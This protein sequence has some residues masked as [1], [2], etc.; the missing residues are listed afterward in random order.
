MEEGWVWGRGE[1][2]RVR[3]SEME[4]GETEVRMKSMKEE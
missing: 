1:V 2:M 3:L 4:G